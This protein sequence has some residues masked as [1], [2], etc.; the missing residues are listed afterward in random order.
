[1]LKNRFS[2]PLIIALFIV[3]AVLTI[4]FTINS[5]DRPHVALN[6]NTARELWLGERY[7][8]IP[9]VDSATG[10]YTAGAKAA[11]AEVNTV[12][13][14]TRSYTA[15]AKAIAC[16]VYPTHDLDLDSATRSYIAWAKSLECQ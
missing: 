8:V 16:A 14:A 3:A 10:S 12:D 13:P 9:N 5:G 6:K 4:S 11:E 2:R 15:Q 7:G 1:M